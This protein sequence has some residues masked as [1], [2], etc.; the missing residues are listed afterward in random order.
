MQGHAEVSTLAYAAKP[1]YVPTKEEWAM[2]TAGL[3][4]EIRL[5]SEASIREV[6]AKDP[7]NAKLSTGDLGPLVQKALE[8]A[9]C[10][11]GIA[12]K[13]KFQGPRCG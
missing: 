1:P 9:G 2:L 13:F 5:K 12:G 10:W 6:L 3:P 8:E 11:A 7:A 4:R